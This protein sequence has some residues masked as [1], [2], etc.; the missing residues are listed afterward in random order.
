[1]PA[2]GAPARRTQPGTLRHVLTHL[3]TPLLMCAG[4]GL[5]YLGAFHQPE[6]HGLRV[7]VVGQGR[8]AQALAR[9]VEDGAGGALDVR[10]VA[11]RREAVD[12]LEHREVA[13]AYLPA[14]GGGTPELLVATAASGTTASVVEAAFTEVAAHRGSPL[15]VTDVTEPA[16]GDPTGQGLFFL[17]VALSIG[18][19]ASVAVIGGAGAALPLRTRAALGLGTAL[20]V[21]VIGTLL[22]GPVFGLVEHGLGGVWALA[23]AYSAGILWLGTGLHTF[24]GRWTTLAMT[25]LFVMLNFT[26]SGGIF[27]PALQPGFFGALHAFWNG[28]GFVEGARG[29]VHFGGLHVGRSVLALALWA[30]A[31]LLMLSI[32]HLAEE[33]RRRAGAGAADAGAAGVG[34][35]AAAAH[36]RASLHD[37]PEVEEEAEEEAVGV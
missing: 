18:S 3:I 35:R 4:M 30:V 28:A 25:T 29:L 6:P 12:A 26:S 32:A 19:Y 21:S 34:S 11:T 20:A 24:L 1:M 33:R 36:H 16:E 31:G 8:A 13:G 27:E 22:A 9:T 37:D 5:A 7:D 17:L 23:W 15:E 10:T 14:A 2:T